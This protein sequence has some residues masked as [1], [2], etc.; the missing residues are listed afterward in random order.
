MANQAVHLPRAIVT[1]FYEQAEPE[2]SDQDRKTAQKAEDRREPVAVLH[3]RMLA[4]QS[5]TQ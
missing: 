1:P 4:R 3:P 5:A 2:Q